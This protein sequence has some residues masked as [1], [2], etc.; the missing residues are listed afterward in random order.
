MSGDAAMQVVDKVCNKIGVACNSFNDFVPKLMKYAIT[1]DV[2]AI[3]VCVLIMAAGIAMIISG[4]KMQEKYSDSGI[5]A[6]GAFVTITAFI[7][8]IGF[9]QNVI[10]WSMNPDVKAV[11][12]ILRLI[13]S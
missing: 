6:L 5:T 10:M 3:I 12:Y 9:V 1:N 8:A 13:G 2:T 7:I 4:C 11:T